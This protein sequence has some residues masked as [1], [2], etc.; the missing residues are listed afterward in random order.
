MKKKIY[1]LMYDKDIVHGG[2][3]DTFEYYYIV[4]KVFK[5]CDVKWRCITSS[6]RTDV[7]NF[8]QDKYQDIESEVWKD[9]EVHRHSTQKFWRNPLIIDILICPT[10]SAIYW[11][12]QNGNIQ[13]AK[14]YIGL[15]DWKDI[16]PKQNKYYKNHYVLGDERVFNYGDS[17]NFIPYRKKILFDKYRHIDYLPGKFDYMLNL[18]LI[19]RRF[20]RDWIMKLFENFGYGHKSFGAYSGFKNQEYYS[21]LNELDMVEL[22]IPPVEGFM[23]LFDNFIY[24]PYKDGTDATPRL[25]PECVFY[26]KGVKYYDEGYQYKIRWIL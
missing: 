24:I 1:F 19:E 7:L 11:F 8:L 5:N 14:Y 22:V 18:S 21:W 15:A 3:F 26:N 13:A 23:G 6:S 16:H 10:N 9:I 17:C 4:K 25:I 12:L 20:S 2:F